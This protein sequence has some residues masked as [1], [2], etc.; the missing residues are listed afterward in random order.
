MKK[1]FTVVFALLLVLCGCANK[2]L[3]II[4]GADGPT[5]IIVTTK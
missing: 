2:D 4:G 1:V 3:G 5:K